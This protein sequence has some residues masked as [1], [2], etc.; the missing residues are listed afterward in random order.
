MR[1]I[2]EAANNLEAHMI[3]HLLDQAG[4]TAHI[5]GEHLQ[6]GAGELPLGGLVAIA[7]ADED[8]QAALKVIK[9][10][11]ARTPKSSD[12]AAKDAATRGFYGPFLA[13]IVGSALGAGIVWSLH[14]GPQTTDGTDWNDDG[15]NDERLFYDGSTLERIELDRN[16]D[17]K[18]DSIAH[19]KLDGL[20]HSI[21]SDDDFD[22]RLETKTSYRRGQAVETE[23]DTDADDKPDHRVRY[24]FGVMESFEYLNSSGAIVKRVRYNGTKL[25][26]ASLDLDADGVWERTYG[27]DRYD[28]PIDIRTSD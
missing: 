20:L 23:I 12:H 26:Q 5:Q 17:G 6:S 7:V 28:E 10:W 21:E 16:F 15:K 25:D 18:V 27:F 24:T 11:E 22:G 19:Y 1:R 4:V 9:E 13:L 3:V 2:Y 14:H 8:A